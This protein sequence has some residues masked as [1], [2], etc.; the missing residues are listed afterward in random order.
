MQQ[1]GAN[2]CRQNGHENPEQ[3]RK[4]NTLTGLTF[5]P[6]KPV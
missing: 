6:T 3:H 5:Q 2:A 4:P 1:N